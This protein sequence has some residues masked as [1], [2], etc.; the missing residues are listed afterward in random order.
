MEYKHFQGP[1]FSM[2]I[3]TDWFISSS[4][5]SQIIILAPPTETGARPNIAV[6]MRVVQD[7]VTLLDLA[8]EAREIQAEEYADY[9]VLGEEDYTETGGIAFQRF[10]Q[11]V[12]QTSGEPVLQVQT[13]ILAGQILFTITATRFASETEGDTYDEVFGH[14]I[15]S[16]RVEV[17]LT[18]VEED[19]PA[20][21][22]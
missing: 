21:E 14:V 18:P 1:G 20:E 17:P 7:D 8:A 5:E 9:E 11:W 22:G 3:P 2:E 13:F 12:P 6:S 19:T 15:R 4:P 16:F 10:Y